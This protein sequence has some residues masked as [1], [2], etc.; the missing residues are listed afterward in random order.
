MRM[1]QLELLL[2]CF[3]LIS[4]IFMSN[5][6]QTA[7]PQANIS[8]PRNSQIS[9]TL[10]LDISNETLKAKTDLLWSSVVGFLS[11]GP[12][13]LKSPATTDP[14]VKTKITNKINNE[15]QT[16]EGV[17]ATNAILSVEITKALRTVNSSSFTAN[18]TGIV[19]IDTTS[20]CKPSDV[21]SIACQNNVE[22]K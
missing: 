6:I 19:T 8:K 14:V 9:A 2:I 15:T 3:V 1:S 17:E 4:S 16:V 22:I 7:Y 18:R 13:I 12:K 21:K 10:T 11:S 20:L 5:L